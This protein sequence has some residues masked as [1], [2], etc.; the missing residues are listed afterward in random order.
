M[1]HTGI[2]GKP[3]L[4]LSMT[5]SPDRAA[6]RRQLR[7]QRVAITAQ[8]RR[9]AEA[10]LT[11]RLLAEP[12]LQRASSVSAYIAC[13]S[14]ID[15]SHAIRGLS[16]RGKQLYFPRLR[17]PQM[18][19]LPAQSRWRKNRHGIAEPKGGKARPL[20]SM[21]VVLVPLLGFDLQAQR[22]GQGGGYYDRALSRLRFRRPIV[23]GLAFDQQL[24]QSIPN[25]PWDQTLDAVITP[26]KTYN[27]RT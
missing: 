14:E 7:K 26:S 20:W 6:L 8:Q 1:S 23:I 13:G 17:G 5:S 3:D 16:Q 12:R 4:I 11:R 2:C 24:C 19:F 18:E 9:A 27:F 10:A 21:S 22:I 15:P 25:E